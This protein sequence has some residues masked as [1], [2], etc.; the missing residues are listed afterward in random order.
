MQLLQRELPNRFQESKPGFATLALFPSD[1]ILVDQDRQ[2]L[3]NL[4]RIAGSDRC[5]RAEGKAAAEDSELTE[6]RL[7]LRCEQV[8]RQGDGVPHRALAN[9]RIA[10][11]ANEKSQPGR[12]QRQKRF[13]RKQPHPGGGQL[14]RQRQPVQP[15][16]DFSDGTR[17]LNCQPE[18]GVR[19]AS[20]LDEERDCFVL[21]QM[22]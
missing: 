1:Q 19:G 2:S 22:G 5:D 15:A 12:H 8:V 16:T 10:R 3:Q 11:S 21:F 17:I 9:R 4:D 13:R 6:E 7:L 20:T 18:S 14:D